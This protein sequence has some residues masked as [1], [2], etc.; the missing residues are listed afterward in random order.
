MKETIVSHKTAVLTKEKGFSWECLS[1]WFNNFHLRA[2]PQLVTTENLFDY[3]N[4]S[5][6]EQSAPTQSLL[7]RWLREVHS[8]HVN[9]IPYKNYPD[10]EITGYYCGEICNTHGESLYP[11]DD[12]YNTY[13][14]A[15]ETGLYE[16]LKLIK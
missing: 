7:Q 4:I 5:S 8:I 10:N 1:F 11:G 14:E 6:Y 3:N 16:A 12:N 2:S 9:P 13:E 15:L